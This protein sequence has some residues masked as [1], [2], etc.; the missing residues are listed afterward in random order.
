MRVPTNTSIKGNSGESCGMSWIDL[1]E[2]AA[3]EPQ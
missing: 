2:G 1:G 3:D